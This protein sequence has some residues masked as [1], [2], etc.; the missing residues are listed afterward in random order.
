MV[1]QVKIEAVQNLAEK[2]NQAKS[3][4]LVDFSKLSVPSQNK[5]RQAVLNAGGQFRVVKNNLFKLAFKKAKTGLSRDFDFE[6][7]EN[8]RGQTAALFAL[9]DE[10][11][12]IKILVKF[13]KENELP[14]LKFGFFENKLIDKAAI[15]EL[16]KI[17]GREELYGQTVQLI[18]SPLAGLVYSL[19]SNLNQ[20]VWILESTKQKTKNEK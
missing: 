9:K 3:L 8:L 14:Q 17:P 19:Q 15:E 20:L 6:K 2:I 7:I 5:L 18:N 13:I 1:K 4:L 16:A 10:L 12:P 11:E